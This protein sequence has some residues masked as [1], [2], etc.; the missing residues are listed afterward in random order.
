MANIPKLLAKHLG[1]RKDLGFGPLTL[2]KVT[3]GVRTAASL[4]DG[5]NPTTTS[6]PCKGFEENKRSGYQQ[7]WQNAQTNNTARASFLTIS[8]LGATLPAG[9][10]P[11]AGDRITSKGKTYTIAADGV[12]RDPVGA[13]YVCTVR[14]P[15]G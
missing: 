15:G 10:E 1:N 8:I 4:A 2:I 3:P 7:F 9:V 13:M 11:M 12:Q 5:T 14:A 6:Y